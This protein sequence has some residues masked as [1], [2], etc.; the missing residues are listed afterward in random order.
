MACHTQKVGDKEAKEVFWEA[1][2]D[3][4]TET[5]TRLEMLRE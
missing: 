5:K 2:S 3:E 1:Y 4:E